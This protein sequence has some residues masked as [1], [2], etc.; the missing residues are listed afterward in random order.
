[1][2][3]IACLPRSGS[4]LLA[5]IT[6]QNA[7]FHAGMTSPV[8]A[9]VGA[10]AGAMYVAPG[11]AMSRRNETAGFIDDEQRGAVLKAVLRQ[12]LPEYSQRHGDL[13][14]QPGAVRPIAG[15]RRII[16][17]RPGDLP[18]G[19]DR[20]ANWATGRSVQPIF[21]VMFWRTPHAIAGNVPIIQ[22]ARSVRPF[23]SPHVSAASV[24]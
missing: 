5:G 7:R 19:K 1:M 24:P 16:S 14:H 10:P 4:T 23:S 8:G 3:F 20:T 15:S 17:G 2:H 11:A 13:R 21:G 6:G 22:V 18:C 12:L 9:P